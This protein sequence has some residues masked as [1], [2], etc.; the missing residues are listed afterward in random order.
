MPID[1]DCLLLRQID[2]R[3]L[4]LLPSPIFRRSSSDS[5]INDLEVVEEQTRTIHFKSEP[6]VTFRGGGRVGSSVST[7]SFGDRVEGNRLGTETG[8]GAG[9]GS[10]SGTNMPFDD[11]DDGACS[12]FLS[13]SIIS[14]LVP[15]RLSLLRVVVI[16]FPLLSFSKFHLVFPFFFLLFLK[17]AR[18]SFC[19]RMSIIAEAM[20]SDARNNV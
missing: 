17:L 13:S 1:N 18:S 7:T 8:T 12:L 9:A 19:F 20:L 15:P 14:S 5:L 10:G 3:R 6:D 11:D 2:T 4:Q 16:A